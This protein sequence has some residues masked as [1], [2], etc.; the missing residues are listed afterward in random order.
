MNLT[1]EIETALLSYDGTDDLPPD[2]I[3]QIAVQGAQIVMMTAQGPM[4]N[5]L[6]PTDS[7]P[8]TGPANE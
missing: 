3:K 6:A 2:I 8:Q 5:P 1:A 4:V 7:Q